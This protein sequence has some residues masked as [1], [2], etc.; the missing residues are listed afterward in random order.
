MFGMAQISGTRRGGRKEEVDAVVIRPGV[1]RIH[2]AGQAAG[3]LACQAEVATS[4]SVG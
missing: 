1:E 2:S 3:P 4:A